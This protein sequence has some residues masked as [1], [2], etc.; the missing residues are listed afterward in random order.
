MRYSRKCVPNKKDITILE[1]KRVYLPIWRVMF[2]ILGKRYVITTTETS[3]RLN[4]L[5]STMTQFSP[6]SGITAYPD[7]CLICSK[8]LKAR[9]YVCN[10]CGTITCDND[11]AECKV[12]G[13]IVC[14]H[15]TVS[16]RKLLVLSDKYCPQCAR[17]QGIT[18]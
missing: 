18:P 12:C 8:E 6:S 14:R 3:G 16:K 10:E 13:K 17:S 4:V 11:K 7:N 1:I 15:H 9:A 5:P 2:S